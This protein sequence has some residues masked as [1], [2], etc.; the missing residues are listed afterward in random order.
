MVRK[1]TSG[2]KPAVDLGL[3]GPTSMPPGRRP[4]PGRQGHVDNDR[5]DGRHETKCPAARRGQHRLGSS[6]TAPPRELRCTGHQVDAAA[7][8][9]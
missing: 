6:P 9:Q 1:G 5:A 2:R 7:V 8:Q 3:R 4:S